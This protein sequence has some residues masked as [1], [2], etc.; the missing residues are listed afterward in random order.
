MRYCQTCG[1]A[2]ADGATFCPNCSANAQTIAAPVA[3][4]GLQPNAAGALTYLA[5]LITGII[6]LVIE[7]Y[8]SD[9]F[10]RFH[11][12]QSIFFNVAWIALWIVWTMV[13]LVLGAVTKGLFFILQIPIDLLLMVGGLGLWIYLMYSAYQGKTTKLPVIGQLAAKQAGL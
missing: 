9:R 2:F 11:A 8:K 3:A 7:P 4:S 5:G 12:F 10:V 13:G 1:A 6:F